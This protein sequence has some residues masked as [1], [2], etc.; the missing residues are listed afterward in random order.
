[1][2]SIIAWTE[3]LSVLHSATVCMCN[4]LQ[5]KQVN[6]D[7]Q[8]LKRILF[9]NV[10]LPYHIDQ[11]LA[12]WQLSALGLKVQHRNDPLAHNALADQDA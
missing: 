12:C 4:I 9:L 1:M 3:G 7:L 2:K 5:R 10:H 6:S 8:Q 11:V